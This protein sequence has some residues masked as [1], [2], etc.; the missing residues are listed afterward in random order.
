MINVAYPQVPGSTTASGFDAIGR[1]TGAT[2]ARI[3]AVER[4]IDAA[5]PSI[6][7]VDAEDL[8]DSPYS[9]RSEA[10]GVARRLRAAGWV[11][12][13]HH[14]RTS[15]RP[16]GLSIAATIYHPSTYESP[17]DLLIPAP[18]RVPR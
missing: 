7:A 12:V 5:E 4:R 3:D 8:C 15:Y 6:D 17:G 16:D 18:R 1:S 2:E 11:V 14:G 9:S 10:L 13:E